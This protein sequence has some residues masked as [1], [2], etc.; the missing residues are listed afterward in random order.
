MADTKVVQKDTVE[1]E[2]NVVSHIRPLCRAAD[3]VI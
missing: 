1:F 2:K 3:I